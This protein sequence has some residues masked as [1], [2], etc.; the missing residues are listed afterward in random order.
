MKDIKTI[1]ILTS[2]GDCGGLN[3]VVKGA[4]QMANACGI[5]AYAILNGYAGLYNLAGTDTAVELNEARIQ[6]IDVTKAGSCIGNSRV[7]ISKINDENKYDRIKAGLARYGI[8]GLVIS[9]GDD[10]GSV[11]VD[12]H[13]NGIPCVH[14][15]KTMDLDLHTYSVGGDSAINNIA[16]AVKS[17]KTTGNSH[18]RIIIVEVFG[19]Y[20]GHTTFRGGI[21]AEADCVLI[22]EVPID[23]DIVYAHM[24]ERFCSRLK[25][26]LLHEAT[27]IIVVA[28][29]L[30]IANQLIV[31]ESYGTDAFGHKK[32][33]GTGKYVR[34][35]LISRLH[36]DEEMKSVYKELGLFVTN[37]NELPE[38]RET[39][40]G[41]LIRSGETSALDACFG[42]DAGAGAVLLL[43]EGIQGV[44]VT[45]IQ[46]NFV[47]Y[48]PTKEAIKQRFVHLNLVSIY[49]AMG[50]CF[51]REPV[52]PQMQ[53]KLMS[54]EHWNYI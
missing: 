52:K 28:E 20:A 25:N 51:G 29:G 36:A 15:P 49:E 6:E 31:D 33:G 10:T 40:P 24:K 22:P 3:A 9:G 26:S 37:M 43:L 5:K 42:R 54:T 7:K 18:N 48:I 47:K 32:M 23:F 44:T 39:A 50:V 53:P 16:K 30:T 2:G 46:N 34:E 45:G 17:V 1:G 38:I 4:A 8:E 14:V 27:Y 41:Y 19:R 12:L 35:Q 21:A 11:V 13:S